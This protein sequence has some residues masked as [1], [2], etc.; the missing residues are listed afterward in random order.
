MVVDWPLSWFGRK[1][2]LIL[3]KKHTFWPVLDWPNQLHV[4]RNWIA[5]RT[6][7]GNKDQSILILFSRVKLD[8]QR[9]IN[10]II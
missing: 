6:C 10:S 2:C 1:Q 7:D 3:K 4:T 5:S 8:N 9:G